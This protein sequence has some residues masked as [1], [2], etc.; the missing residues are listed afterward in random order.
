M[1]N[2]SAHNNSDNALGPLA[3]ENCGK[4]L[5]GTGNGVFVRVLEHH[6]YEV[7]APRYVGFYTWCKRPCQEKMLV[8]LGLRKWPTHWDDISDAANPLWYPHWDSKT[9]RL[10]ERGSFS[11]AA[12]EKLAAA[13]VKVARAAARKPT[14]ED[15]ARYQQLRMMYGI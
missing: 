2:E 4:D 11:T 3:C 5:L 1:I 6:G 10:T 15:I 7:A 8:A 13:K 14:A 12:A 9:S